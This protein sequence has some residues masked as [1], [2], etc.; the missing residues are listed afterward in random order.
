M[1]REDYFEYA[2]KI[3]DKRDD[4]SWVSTP[5][6]EILPTNF[7][8]IL[9]YYET[10]V[11]KVENNEMYLVFLQYQYYQSLNEHDNLVLSDYAMIFYLQDVN[12]SRNLKKLIQMSSKEY[13]I[14]LMESGREFEDYHL[15]EV[16]RKITEKDMN[17][18]DFF[19]NL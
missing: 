5:K 3:F 2:L 1:K 4:F 18:E 11:S 16:I 9:D 8:K 7:V 10:L 17:I 13:N 12:D 15:S 14:L 19:G 6:I